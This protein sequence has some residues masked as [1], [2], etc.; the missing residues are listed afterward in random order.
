MI[1]GQAN[2]VI[3]FLDG[4]DQRYRV[5]GTPLRRWRIRLDLLNESEIQQ[6]EAFFTEQS[7]EYSM[8]TFP[9]PVTGTDIPN[10]RFGE[11][12]FF[13]QYVDVNVNSTSFWIIETRG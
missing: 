13:S 2:Q 11:P 8:F 7:G 12:A 6:L 10:C 5:Q 3:R 4:N 1:T 9:D